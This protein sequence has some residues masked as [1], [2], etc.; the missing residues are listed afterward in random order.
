MIARYAGLGIVALALTIGL[1]IGGAFG[2]KEYSRYQGREDAK[3]DLIRAESTRK[4]KVEE[5]KAA[6]LSAV[7]LAEAE[8][9]RAGG[10]AKANAIIADSITP[11]YL[12]YFYIQQL[13]EVE[14]AGGTII[15]VPTEAGL[16]ILEAG[17]K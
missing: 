13:A 15:Y 9:L 4:I 3:N 12:R 2:C 5:A 8:V 11:A 1:L 17:R 7:E 6:K 10:V 16:P 14:H